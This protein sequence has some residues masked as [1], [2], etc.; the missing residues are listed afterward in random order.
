[1]T[2]AEIIA[3]LQ[4]HMAGV[5]QEVSKATTDA[6]LN[7]F[8]DMLVEQA[9]VSMKNQ[10]QSAEKIEVVIDDAQLL[11][12]A[13]QRADVIETYLSD[14]HGTKPNRLISCRSRIDDI[15]GEGKPRTEL[16]LR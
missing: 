14:K 10:D 6:F 8:R 2:K 7:A 13:G 15:E 16:S 4:E 11:S 1:M 9:G 5:G 3:A 12:L